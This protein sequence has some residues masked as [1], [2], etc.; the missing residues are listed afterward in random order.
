MGCVAP[1]TV[2]NHSNW[3]VKLKHWVNDKHSQLF[4]WN[5][6]RF[7]FWN[8]ANGLHF[9]SHDNGL[10]SNQIRHTP[11]RDSDSRSSMTRT[12][13]SGTAF[14]FDVHWWRKVFGLARTLRTLFCHAVDHS[15]LLRDK[16]EEGTV[17][18]R[19]MKTIHTN[20]ACFHAEC[21]SLTT[22]KTEFSS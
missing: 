18:F 9:F 6:F 11:S 4:K 17:K 3:Y 19:W 1:H 5:L 21:Y 2:V 7:T 22:F 8:F 10:G 12:I 14:S 16:N 13:T 15:V 20:P